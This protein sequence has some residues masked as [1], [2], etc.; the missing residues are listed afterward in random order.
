[1]QE[2][3]FQVDEEPYCLWDPD[4]M[5][6]NQ[7]FLKGLDANF[8]DYSI[9]VHL[10]AEDMQRASVAL[11][12]ALDHALE[13]LFSLLGAYVQ[14]PDCAYAWLAKC[15]TPA[16]RS[17]VRRITQEQPNIFTKLSIAPVTWTTI[18][19]SV[20]RAYLPDTERQ[21]ETIEQ[22][23]VLW[24]RL[25][26]ELTDP[27]HID[28][29]NALKHG[30]RVQRGGFAISVGKEPSLG[31]SP[32]TSEMYPL[33][34]ADYGSSFFTVEPLATG[35]KTRSLRVSYTSV[36][37]SIERLILLGQ[38]AYFSINN[39][40]SALRVENGWPGAECMFLRPEES[41]DFDKPWKYSAV[42]TSMKCVHEVSG[43]N[44]MLVTREELIG[45]LA[46]RK[47]G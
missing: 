20:F 34:E 31:V 11:R 25:A 18:A 41:E 19:K 32:P 33:G 37:W 46:S 14:A 35:V 39:V 10:E 27:I 42:L 23:A 7:E 3:I 47:K 28:E 36:N 17:L 5:A 44:D 22:F 38:H 12:L 9:K 15:S 24:A 1:M 21:A 6:R 8:F 43:I 2:T 29:Y 45:K 13:T 4:L 16:L 40:V 30:F 26:T